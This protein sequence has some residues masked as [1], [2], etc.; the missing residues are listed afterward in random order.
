MRRSFI[1]KNLFKTL[2]TDSWAPLKE[3][4]NSLKVLLCGL[5]KCFASNATDEAD[6]S[7][8]KYVRNQYRSSTTNISLETCLHT[9]QFHE[10]QELV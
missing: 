9:K 3:R 7:A 10:L 6:F 4:F 8:L 2:E 5:E 1:D